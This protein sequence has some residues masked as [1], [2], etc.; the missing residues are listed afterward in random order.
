MTLTDGGRRVLALLR[1]G[2]PEVEAE[3]S[4][5]RGPELELRFDGDTLPFTARLDGVGETTRAGGAVGAVGAAT[6]V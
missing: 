5:N 3:V 4:T 1:V 2:E 6:T